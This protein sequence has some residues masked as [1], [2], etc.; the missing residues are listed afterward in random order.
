MMGYISVTPADLDTLGRTI[1]GEARGESHDGKIA[2]GWVIRNRLNRPKRFR[3][4][5]S[6]VCRQPYQFSCWNSKDPN[7]PK[8]QS[9]TLADPTFKECYSAG[10]Q[11]C[12]GIADDPT[13]GAQFYKV[14]GAKASWAD[15]HTP[16]ATIG[17]HEFYNDVD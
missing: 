9:V 11:V 12:A 10:Q 14:I 17:H 1:Y 8:L 5:I 13:H 15:G 16:C 2:V 7:L 4:T 6:G 3:E